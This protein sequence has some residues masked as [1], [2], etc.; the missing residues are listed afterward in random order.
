MASTNG[1]LMPWRFLMIS[2][3]KWSSVAKDAG[4]MMSEGLAE[5]EWL[6]GVLESAIYQDYEPTLHR[7]TSTPLPAEPTVTVMKAD[8][9]LEVDPSTV[10][11]IDAKSAFDH[12]LCESQLE[13]IADGQRKSY[14]WSGGAYKH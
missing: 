11:V 6:S 13:V 12:L 4:F 2:Q 5:C 9:H 1:S 10:C 14:V 3:G 8:G 7:G